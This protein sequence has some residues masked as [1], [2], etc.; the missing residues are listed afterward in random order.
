MV[1]H[2][3]ARSGARAEATHDPKRRRPAEGRG[4]RNRRRRPHPSSVSG[5]AAGDDADAIQLRAANGVQDDGV[6]GV[7]GEVHYFT[8][9]TP[10]K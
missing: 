10:I 5:T 1:A 2:R 6:A 4:A 8:G 9:A 3:S 7:R